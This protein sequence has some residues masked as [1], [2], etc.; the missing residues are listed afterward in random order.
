MITYKSHSKWAEN[1]QAISRRIMIDRPSNTTVK[2]IWSPF[3]WMEYSMSIVDDGLLIVKNKKKR[4]NAD[5]YAF[6]YNHA[7]WQDHYDMWESSMSMYKK[8]IREQL[9]VSFNYKYQADL[10]LSCILGAV[11]F[12]KQNDNDIIN[13]FP[14]VM[15]GSPVYKIDDHP[16]WNSIKE[17]ST[18]CFLH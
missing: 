10:N 6:Y 18:E 1:N 2:V 16:L 12:L 17:M 3:D 4:I 8:P 15:E 14:V 13:E 11:S 7:I 5:H 9:R